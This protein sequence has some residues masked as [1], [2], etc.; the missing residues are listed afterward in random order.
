MASTMLQL[1]QQATGELG[2]G[3][4]TY[5]AGNPATDTIQQLALLN[6]LGYELQQQFDW[7][8]AI[9]EYRFTIAYLATT[10]NTTSGSAVVTN[11]PTTAAIT[12]GTYMAIGNGIPVDTYVQSVDSGTQ[13]TL[14]QNATAT[15]TAVTLNFCKTK[16]S[17]PSDYDRPVNKT[18]WDKSKHWELMGPVTAEQW[19]FLKSGFV[20]TGPRI[21]YRALGG[22]FQIWPATASSEYLGFEYMSKNWAFDSGGTAKGSFTVDT[23]T[24][25]FPD[26]LMV[27][28]LKLKYWEIKGFDTTALNRDFSAQLSIAK[29]SDKGAPT[30]SMSPRIATILIG[31]NQIPDS[32]YGS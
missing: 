9:T 11:I 4:P 21:S 12:A 15:G 28:G 29:A 27:L 5:V 22:Y 19:Q 30:L 1:V 7:Q 31:P 26:R 10:G 25:V 14:S 32:G 16:Y 8:H 2:L 13:V 17:F 24:C 6:A 18:Q 3:V 20:S 23:D